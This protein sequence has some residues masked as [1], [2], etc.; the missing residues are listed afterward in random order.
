MKMPTSIL[1]LI[2]GLLLCSA[3]GLQA[4]VIVTGSTTGTLFSNGLTTAAVYTT[5]AGNNNF[6]ERNVRNDR[7]NTQTF[8]VGT[9]FTLDAVYL[10]YE[11]GGYND[12][13]ITLGIYNVA[14]VTA[15]TLSLG[16]LMVSGTFTSNATTRAAAGFTS[17]GDI[18]SLLKFDFT[19]IDEVSLA[20]TS[21]TA[22]YA[23]QIA[24]TTGANP[25][26]AWQRAGG[27]LYSGGS[28]YEAG[29]I[30]AGLDYAMAIT[31]AAVPEPSRMLLLGLSLFGMLTIRRRKK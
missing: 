8:Q 11:N 4:A 13:D 30:N 28:S 1:T 3:G 19:D 29:G 6:N 17:S 22:G 21:G 26:F 25:V 12:G 16:S 24:T 20:A 5:S 10:E 23:L 9:T 2:A 15:G 7:Q 14:D 31:A 18:T 27:D